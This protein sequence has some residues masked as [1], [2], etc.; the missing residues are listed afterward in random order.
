M[1]LFTARSNGWILVTY[2]SNDF[3]LLHDALR[4]WEV[5]NPHEGILILPDNIPNHEQAQALDVFVSADLPITGE[6]Y[7]WNPHVSW[8]RRPFPP[9]PRAAQPSPSP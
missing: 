6:L 1:H 7:D 3:V 9:R 8:I 2:N 4:R 5:R